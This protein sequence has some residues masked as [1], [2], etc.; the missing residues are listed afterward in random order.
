MSDGDQWFTLV[1]PPW[2]GRGKQAFSSTV[3][4]EL[5]EGSWLVEGRLAFSAGAA[6]SSTS[7]C[8]ATGSTD[9]SALDLQQMDHERQQKTL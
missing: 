9:T 1:T 2:G 7:T 3:P 5:E 8:D 4:A 6:G